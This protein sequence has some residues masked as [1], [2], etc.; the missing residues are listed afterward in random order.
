MMFA[1]SSGFPSWTIH[2]IATW[3]GAAP[4][5]IELIIL[6]AHHT[7][8]PTPLGDSAALYKSDYSRTDA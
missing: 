4:A 5:I 2:R 6:A 7:T 8:G 3:Q 1:T